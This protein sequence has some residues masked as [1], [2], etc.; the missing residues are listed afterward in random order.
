VRALL[1]GNLGNALLNGGLLASALVLLL[2]APHFM[3]GGTSEE[4]IANLVIHAH[5]FIVLMAVTILGR[6]LPLRTIAAFFFLGMFASSFV[7]LTL[8][9][10][11]AGMI[12]DDRML[13]SLA[14]PALEEGVKAVPLILFFWYSARRGW[15]PSITDG[16]V[17]GFALGA[18]MAIHEDA[19]YQRLYAVGT[20][21]GPLHLLIPTLG[22]QSTLSRIEVN[23]FYHSGWGSLIGLG[24]GAWFML[25]RRY[26]VAGLLALGAYLLA[27]FDHAIGNF[28]ILSLGPRNLGALWTLDLEGMLPV[29]VF[30]VGLA[31]AVVA[32]VLILRRMAAED[33]LLPGLTPSQA[34]AGVGP[35]L[36]G[37][38]RLQAARN[39][40]R[41]RRALH[42]LVWASRGKPD[43]TALD[44][45]V[46]RL[47]GPAR[48][49]G[50][51]ILRWGPDK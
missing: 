21:G 28:I 25:R 43:A 15:Q 18:G 51:T 36:G 41:A 14:L 1:F 40:A 20:D 42:Y 16:V 47:A 30:V 17:L 8:S 27:T 11:L 29:L 7:A 2:A 38:L 23:G 19:L 35:T 48:S 45:Q 6:T 5:A 9:G 37:L 39:Y 46:G 4:F 10:V 22:S 34:L 50:M 26:R 24:V 31:A 12:R 13:D 32:E 3:R 33:P 44:R 49:F